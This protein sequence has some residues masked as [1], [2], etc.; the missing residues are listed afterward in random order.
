MYEKGPITAVSAVGA[1]AAFYLSMFFAFIIDLVTL[2][3]KFI[4]LFFDF[5]TP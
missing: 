1:F 2:P 4:L 5:S 3:F